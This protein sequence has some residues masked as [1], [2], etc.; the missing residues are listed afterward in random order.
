MATKKQIKYWSSIK[1]EGHP[2]WAKNPV[3]STI[4]AWLVNI[5][6]KASK[7]ENIVCDEVCKIYDWALLKNKDYERN[8]ENFI[9][10]CRSCHLRYDL[11]MKRRNKYKEIYKKRKKDKYGKFI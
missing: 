2:R 3:Y 9:M 5:Y 1:G 10:L 4:H 6:G 7:C 8:R 11:N